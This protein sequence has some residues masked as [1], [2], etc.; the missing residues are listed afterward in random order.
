[1][2]NAHCHRLS[3]SVRS[4]AYNPNNLSIF[5]D[6]LQPDNATETQQQLEPVVPQHSAGEDAMFPLVL[7]FLMVCVYIYLQ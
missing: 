2:N 4:G 5:P 1:M 3:S 7:R 6:L